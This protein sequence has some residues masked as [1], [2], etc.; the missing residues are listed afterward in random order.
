MPV[1]NCEELQFE[2]VSILATA[3]RRTHTNSRNFAELESSSLRRIRAANRTESR[4]QG[5]SF[6]GRARD[7]DRVRI[8][9]LSSG[10]RRS[11]KCKCPFAIGDRFGTLERARDCYTMALWKRFL[12]LPAPR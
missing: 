10:G 11:R 2:T 4:G 8:L 1:C 5:P 6:N 7:G 12:I 9:K 3:R